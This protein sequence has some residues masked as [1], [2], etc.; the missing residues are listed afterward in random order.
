[1]NN[2][3]L[4]ECGLLEVIKDKL[5]S[6]SSCPITKD[7]NLGD[8]LIL[9][10]EIRNNTSVLLSINDFAFKM[11]VEKSDAQYKLDLDMLT[12]MQKFIVNNNTPN[13]LLMYSPMIIC[14][15]KTLITEYLDTLFQNW[16]IREHKVIDWYSMLFQVLHGL[17]VMDIYA[18]I[19][20]KIEL[21]N[22]MCKKIYNQYY[23]YVINNQI[24]YVPI[25]YLFKIGVMNIDSTNKLIPNDNFICDL[26]RKI[27]IDEMIK[28]Y[29]LD[30]LIKMGKKDEKF[31]SFFGKLRIDVHKTYSKEDEPLRKKFMLY[32]L[33]EYLLDNNLHVSNIVPNEIIN[34]TKTLEN[35]NY[36]DM[37]REF[38]NIFGIKHEYGKTFNVDS[39]KCLNVTLTEL[40]Q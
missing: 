21:G 36:Y 16:Y 7:I 31:N 39:G 2:C 13:L 22:I 24:Y 33:C 35:K 4:L 40:E 5:R 26:P 32:K 28:N 18:K 20:V 15:K 29:S 12:K 11:Y 10:Y 9:K 34:F 17:M 3:Q 38:E 23:K 19:N 25:N 27:I 14:N 30:E 1:M 6:L 37:F 8:E